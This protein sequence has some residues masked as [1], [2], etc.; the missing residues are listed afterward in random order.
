MQKLLCSRK[1]WSLRTVGTVSEEQGFWLLHQ[2]FF[3][4]WVLFALAR[5]NPV[6]I[7]LPPSSLSLTQTTTTTPL[8]N[9]TPFSR[10]SYTHKPSQWPSFRK[11]YF[12]ATVFEK[13]S[14][15]DCVKQ[16]PASQPASQDVVGGGSMN[17][18][19]DN[20]DDVP[21]TRKNETA[22]DRPRRRLRRQSRP[23]RNFD[24][25]FE[26]RIWDLRPC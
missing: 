1:E 16:L 21:T 7:F 6:T 20:H 5:R 8:D 24:G 2:F 26:T 3:S 19:D 4:C 25:G 15:S 13:E 12:E 14:D 18:M 9:Q 23:C 10:F 11:F 22:T 17:E